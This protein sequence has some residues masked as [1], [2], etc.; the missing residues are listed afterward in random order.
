MVFQKTMRFIIPLA[1]L[2]MTVG[3]GDEDSSISL[4]PVKG[5]ITMNGEALANAQIAFVPDPSNK[6]QTPGG[7]VTGPA[8]TYLARFKTR[9]GL[10]PG[11]YKVSISPPEDTGD[12][13]IDAA[14]QEDFKDDPFMLGEMKKGLAATGKA[15]GKRPPQPKVEFD[16]EVEADG[17]T[18]D[19]DVKRA[20]QDAAK[21][22][23]L[24]R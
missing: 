4:A 17:S 20:G 5:K 1:V 18:I 15:R 16:A 14:L 24:G 23:T 19:H 13:K 6:D 7:D 2:I 9:S 8:G 12:L 21:T 10:A 11:K 22:A 3:C